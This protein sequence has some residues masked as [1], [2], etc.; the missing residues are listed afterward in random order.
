MR[1]NRRQFLGQTTAAATAALAAAASLPSDQAKGQTTVNTGD[2]P[3]IDCHQHLWDLEKFKLLWIKPGTLLGRSYLMTDY[4]EAIEG[5]GI[6]HAIYMEVDVELSQQQAEAEHL[7]EICKSGNAPTRAAVVSGRPASDEFETYV[8]QFQGNR[9]MKGIRQVLHGAS[10]PAGYCLQD[11]FVRGIRLL[12]ELGLS[13]DLCLRPKE[14]ADGAKLAERCPGTRFIVDHCGNADPKAFFKAGDSRLTDAKTDHAADAWRRDM[15]GLAKHKNV[16]C[17]IS[18]I[19]ARV[20]RQWSA[21]DLAPIVNHCLDTFG[22][23]RVVV[24]SDWPVCLNGAPL[25]DWVAALKQIIAN[26]SVVQQR[27]L[28]RDNAA[29]FYALRL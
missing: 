15:E 9:Y 27:Q 14:L 22:P 4:L 25:C 21:E 24:G 11:S 6:K 26:R 13:F 20:P 23:S 17:K 7:I 28:L 3:I 5:T 16:I 2:I 12:G 10:T 8:G 1:A 29:N 19:V 18:G